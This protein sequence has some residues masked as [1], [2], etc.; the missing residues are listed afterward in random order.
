VP[1]LVTGGDD[2]VEPGADPL[3]LVG[4]EAELLRE[5][6]HE[7]PFVAGAGGRVV[8]VVLAGPH[9]RREHRLAGGDGEHTLL[10]G[11]ERVAVAGRFL[12]GFLRR[13]FVGGWFLRWFLRRRFVRR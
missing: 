11:G 13:R 3:D 7:R 10:D 12:R 5:R 8:E 1:V 2:L 9:P 6:E 4:R